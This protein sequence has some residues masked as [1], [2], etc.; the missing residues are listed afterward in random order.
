M[1]GWSR[2]QN[3]EV[4]S[5]STI[6]WKENMRCNIKIFGIDVGSELRSGPY[7]FSGGLLLW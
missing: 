6:L 1:R 3:V 5:V 7:W 2:S 4:V